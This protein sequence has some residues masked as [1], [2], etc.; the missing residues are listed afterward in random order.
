MQPA[1]AGKQQRRGRGGADVAE[2]GSLR[3][4]DRT[5]ERAAHHEPGAHRPAAG[6]SPAGSCAGEPETA[7]TLHGRGDHGGG[8]QRHVHG[9]REVTKPVGRQTVRRNDT[10]GGAD[11]QRRPKQHRTGAGGH[12]RPEPRRGGAVCRPEAPEHR[13]RRVYQRHH[14]PDRRGAGD[15]A[16]GDDEAVHHQLFGSSRRTQ[17]VLAHL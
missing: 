10:G 15:T 14:P 8:D 13:V 5:E 2:G 17:R 9:V 4:G 12:Y 3:R 16:G 1:P 6:R 11:R 7:W